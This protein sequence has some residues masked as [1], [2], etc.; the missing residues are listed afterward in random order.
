[1]VFTIGDWDTAVETLVRMPSLLSLFDLG[2]DARFPD[3][4]DA[5][6]VSERER[7]VRGIR[8]EP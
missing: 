6:R 3:F 4:E 1:M 7:G 8:L 2:T 5:M